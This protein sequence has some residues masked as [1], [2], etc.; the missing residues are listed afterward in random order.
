MIASFP[1]MGWNSW[2]CYGAAVTE[3]T[4]RRNADYMAEHLKRFGWEYIVVD[5]LDFE[6][7]VLLDRFLGYGL[8]TQYAL[9][10]CSVSVY[11]F[12]CRKRKAQGAENAE[13]VEST[14]DQDAAMDAF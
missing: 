5:I 6:R 1:P 11:Q 8:D 14:D 12:L 10:E 4:V 3:E 2:D 13:N 7:A 9:T